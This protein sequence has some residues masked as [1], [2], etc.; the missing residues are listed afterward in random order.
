MIRLLMICML[1]CSGILTAGPV[2]PLERLPVLPPDYIAPPS[3]SERAEISSNRVALATVRRRQ[4]QV[5]IALAAQV[6]APT[7]TTYEA[8]LARAEALEGVQYAVDNDVPLAAGVSTTTGVIG[9]LA[10]Y[11]LAR[12]KLISG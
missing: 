4:R 7:G 1:L 10:G 9:A 3:P 2:Q 8:V 6:G 11:L 12:R 5:M